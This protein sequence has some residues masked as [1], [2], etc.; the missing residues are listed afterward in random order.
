MIKVFK[1]VINLMK[2][3]LIDYWE[4]LNPKPS[5]PTET[6]YWELPN[7]MLIPIIVF[8]IIIYLK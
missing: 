7:W 1:E 4:W 5:G 8:L 2:T 3:F 6:S